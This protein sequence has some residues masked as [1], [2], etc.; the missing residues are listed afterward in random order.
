MGSAPM[1]YVLWD[2]FLR[3]N[4]KD[5]FWHNRDRFVLS[6]GHGCALL[7]SLL[8]LTGFDFSL[9]DLKQF[10]QW[11]SRTPGHPEY[12]KTPG[13]EATTGPLGQGF[14][15][16][17][18]MAIAETALA[19]RFNKPG[20]PVVDHFT[21]VEASDGDLM[22][23]IASEA[24]SLAGHL[25]LHK[26][27]VMY[28]DNKITIEGATDLAFT[29]DRMAR[30]AAYGWHTQRVTDGNDIQ[31]L[32]TAIEAARLSDKPAFIDVRT[33]IGYGSPHKQD[34]ASAHGEAL[35]EEEVRLTKQNL[36]WPIE[37]SFYVPEEALG[38]FRKAIERG[39]K[40]QEEWQALFQSY[41]EEYPELAAEFHRVMQ[42][43]L[44]AGWDRD[45]PVFNP[46][47]GPMATRQASGQAINAV[48][49]R[50]PE[51]MGGAAD[52]APS[53]LT[54][55]K[56][57]A[58]FERDSLDGRNMHFGIREHAMGGILNGMALHRGLIPYGATFLIFSDYMRPPMRLAAMNGLPVIYVFT[59]DSI[60]LGEDG[61]TH[62]PV[63]Q[64]LGLRSIP[65]MVVIR[66]AD[67]NE[68]SAAWKVAIEIENRPVALVLTRQKL[69]ILD[70]S[71]FPHMREGVKFGGYILSR[72]KD[73]RKP[74]LIIVATGSE[75][76]LALQTQEKL[77]ADDVRV[78]VVS[79]PSWNLLQQQP[80]RYRSE[81]FPPGI[82]VLAVEAGVSL[83]WKPYIGEG[84]HVIGV[85]TFGA[86]APGSTVMEKYGFNAD[87][88][89]NRTLEILKQRKSNT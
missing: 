86:S 88:V 27:I 35:G 45:L 37:P 41:S 31:A 72:A 34:T 63:E 47:E 14:S 22:E 50:L 46:S 16:A 75:I 56:K 59:H 33:H 77:L 78:Q 18:G 61:P 1:A 24:A 80:D 87:N 51:L 2:R 3:Y 73:G 20:F 12:G 9:D 84:V 74:D 55:V 81:L 44:P 70:P 62:Q 43:K 42:R 4:P 28:D 23:G 83:G 30:F 10:R 68:T 25:G 17:V 69:P 82:P 52:L 76:H 6:A 48:A 60:G 89:R 21:Y 58:N 54:L 66:P 32:A 39:R 71:R 40:D 13:V 19:A 49:S 15:N 8:Y 79:L 67:A 85:D 26:L 64:L 7:Y 57:E 38:H 29:E 11:G 36:G 65:D 53:T 5:P